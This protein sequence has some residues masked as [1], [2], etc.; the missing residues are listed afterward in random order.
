MK[1]TF[2]LFPFGRYPDSEKKPD[3]PAMEPIRRQLSV[4]CWSGSGG[5]YGSR[6]QVKDAK[7]Q[8]RKAL[9]G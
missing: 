8:V 2:V 6:A 7:R 1:L 4:G 3:P 9:K 5:L